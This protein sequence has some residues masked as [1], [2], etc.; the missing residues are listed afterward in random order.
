MKQTY[1]VVAPVHKFDRDDIQGAIFTK[2]QSTEEFINSYTEESRPFIKVYTPEDFMY[3]CNLNLIN[4]EVN[5]VGTL[6]IDDKKSIEISWTTDDVLLAARNLKL[7]CSINQAKDILKEILKKHD[8][9]DGITW[10]TME[11][12]VNL[13][14]NETIFEVGTEVRVPIRALSL[15]E[16]SFGVHSDEILGTITEISKGVATIKDNKGDIWDIEVDTLEFPEEDEDE[17]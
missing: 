16:Q 17:Y 12:Y 15:Q 2:H 3:G 1:I 10:E 6:T 11:C 9:N 5:W 7:K 4:T 14:C 13:Y 8:S